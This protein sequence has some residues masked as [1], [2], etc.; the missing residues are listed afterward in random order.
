[1]TDTFS[2]SSVRVP[3]ST[4]DKA[5]GT[6]PPFTLTAAVTAN[7]ETT[8]TAKTTD[9]QLAARAVTPHTIAIASLA[10]ARERE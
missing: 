9:A 3:R 2:E 1:M 8:K 10:D 4:D 7:D 5:A 6:P